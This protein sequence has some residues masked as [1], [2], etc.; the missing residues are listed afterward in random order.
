MRARIEALLDCHKRR[1]IVSACEQR[2]NTVDNVKGH[3]V[4]VRNR[5]E[6]VNRFAR[7]VAVHFVLFGKGPR[8]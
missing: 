5:T 1:E 8:G 6:V 4:G 3:C 7:G 2:Y